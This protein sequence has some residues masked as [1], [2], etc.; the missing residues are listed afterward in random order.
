MKRIAFIVWALLLVMSTRGYAEVTTGLEGLYWKPFQS[1]TLRGSQQSFFGGF[2]D[3]IAEALPFSPSYDWGVRGY[4]NY[5]CG[6]YQARVS[7]L[8][9]ESVARSEKTSDVDNLFTTGA[10]NPGNRLDGLL[11][12]QYKNVDVRGGHSVWS[13]H[14]WALDL[15]LNGRYI[16]LATTTKNS[17]SNAN[18]DYGTVIFQTF[19]GGAF[20]AGLQLE[21]CWGCGLRGTL[22][23]NP[24]LAIGVRKD[25]DLSFINGVGAQSIGI[26]IPNETGFVPGVDASLGVHYGRCVRGI[27][28]ALHVGYEVNYVWDLFVT[29]VGVTGVPRE[30]HNTDGLGFAGLIFGLSGQF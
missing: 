17:G 5:A 22:E 10:L 3:I 30:V 15:F 24:I 19:R 29:E 28:V 23:L 16:D 1:T 6:C 13:S 20:G 8:W 26:R 9:F 25:N 11:L 4:A 14:C 12:F 21:R 18:G 2:A 7:F 27:D